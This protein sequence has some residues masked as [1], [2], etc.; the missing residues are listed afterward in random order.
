MNGL[1][2]PR[3]IENPLVKDRVTF[4]TTAAESEGKYEYVKVELAPGGGTGLHYHLTFA[5]HF[6]A[7]EGELHLEVDGIFTTL[8]PGESATA[9]PGTLHRFFNLGTER[10]VFHVKID[11]ARHFEKMLRIGY[12]MA[13]DGKVN[14]K[15]G[16]PYSLLEAAVIF[17]LGETY[18]NRIPIWLQRGVFGF[19]YRIA[20]RRG[21]EERL[22][23][24]YCR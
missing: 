22:L 15:N 14:P 12:G 18:M 8:R 13:R 20:Q 1:Q 21:V 6:E 9:G 23:R 4:L 11:P 5:E 16:M 7:V 24:A 19:L 10:I 2:L 17:T 3:S